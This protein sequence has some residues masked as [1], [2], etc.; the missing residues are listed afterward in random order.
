MKFDMLREVP[1]LGKPS[2]AN[3]AFKGFIACVDPHV[4]EKIPCLFK[5]LGAA[6]IPAT[7]HPPFAVCLLAPFK[8]DVERVV[9]NIYFVIE[10]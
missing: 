2:A 10:L 6:L 4:V 1:I 3:M 8:K 5:G 7:E 9:R